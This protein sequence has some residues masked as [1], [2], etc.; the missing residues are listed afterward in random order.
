MLAHFAPEIEG[1][2]ES[3]AGRRDARSLCGTES[4]TD[5]NTTFRRFVVSNDLLESTILDTILTNGR[6]KWREAVL[7]VTIDAHFES[8]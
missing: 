8:A 6:Q 3:D 7:F 2:R 4:V 1:D 5:N